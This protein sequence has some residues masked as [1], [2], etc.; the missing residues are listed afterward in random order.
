MLASILSLGVRDYV[1]VLTF[2]RCRLNSGTGLYPLNEATTETSPQ[3]PFILQLAVPPVQ[4]ERRN[5][6]A[7]FCG[8]FMATVRHPGFNSCNRQFSLFSFLPEQVEFPFNSAFICTLN[9]RCGLYLVH[10]R[11]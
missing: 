3:N 4:Y 6:R 7:V 8:G 2:I 10:N 1:T 5:A 9:S 11:C